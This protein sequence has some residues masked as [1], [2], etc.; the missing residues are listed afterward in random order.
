MIIYQKMHLFKYL[1]LYS[2]NMKKRVK[3]NKYPVKL[4]VVYGVDKIKKYNYKGLK[5][6]KEWIQKFK[7]AKLELNYIKNLKY[8]YD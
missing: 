5:K 1:I 2:Y 3:F 6:N 7:Y 4:L 8:I